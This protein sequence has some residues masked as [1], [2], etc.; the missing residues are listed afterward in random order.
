VNKDAP[1]VQPH[2]TAVCANLPGAV[3][4][5]V[6]LLTMS[7]CAKRHEMPQEELFRR[8]QVLEAGIAEAQL[9]V[10]SATDCR[11]AHGPSEEGVCD[12]SVALC[13]LTEGVENQDALQ[14]CLMAADSCRA[15]RERASA[16]CATSAGRRPAAPAEAAR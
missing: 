5:A 3:V 13:K 14:R 2:S 12:P 7:A 1:P 8:I 10:R 6:A 16:L 4:A 9:A 15:A 11:E